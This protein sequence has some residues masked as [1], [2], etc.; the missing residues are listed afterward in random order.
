MRISFSA[1][2]SP[3]LAARKQVLCLVAELVDVGMSRECRHDVSSIGLL[4]ACQALKENA[5]VMPSG[6][7]AAEGRRA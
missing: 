7:P 6:S 4:S 2:G 5:T 3:V 1:S